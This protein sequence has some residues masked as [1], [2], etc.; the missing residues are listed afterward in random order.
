MGVTTKPNRL[1]K[2]RTWRG[3][4][5]VWHQYTLGLAGERFFRELKDRGR[6]MASRCPRCGAAYLLPKLYCPACFVACEEWVE[7]KPRGV[8]DTFTVLHEG[9][10]EEEL[11]EPVVVA[12]V[13]FP[14][15]KGGLVHRLGEVGRDGPAVGME[16]EM[17]LRPERRGGLDDILYFRPV[18][19]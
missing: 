5:P 2:I 3:S 13:T 10:E 19:K 11:K 1:E 14:G 4:V 8:V 12:F 9:L 6:L 15:V 17:V 7:I 18:G 16:V